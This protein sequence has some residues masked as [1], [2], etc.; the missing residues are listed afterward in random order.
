[1]SKISTLFKKLWN[2]ESRA[3]PTWINAQ[4]F[5]ILVLTQRWQHLFQKYLRCTYGQMHPKV[6]IYESG[7]QQ[8]ADFQL[9]SS[10]WKKTIETFVGYASYNLIIKS[11]ARARVVVPATFFHG[12]DCKIVLVLLYR[13]HISIHT[14]RIWTS[15]Y[16]NSTEHCSSRHSRATTRWYVHSLRAQKLR[17]LMTYQILPLPIQTTPE[18]IGRR[19]SHDEEI[20]RNS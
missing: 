7:L 14:S 4:N 3:K 11:A 6:W 1:M 17:G 16:E 15:S 10:R 12:Y 8:K 2:A 19:L 18:K 13:P 20:V 9:A 5:L